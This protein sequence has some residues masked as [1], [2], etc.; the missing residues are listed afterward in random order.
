MKSFRKIQAHWA[1]RFLS[2][3][4]L[5]SLFF[6]SSCGSRDVLEV[7]QF[8]LRS[9]AETNPKD[10]LIRAE[11]QKRLYGAVTREERE[12]R[13]G[14]YYSVRWRNAENEKVRIVFDYRQA[15]TGAQIKTLS[16]EITGKNEGVVEFAIAGEN[17]EVG[18]RVLSWRVRVFDAGKLLGEK[19]SYLWE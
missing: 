3:A 6:L 17:Y 1:R 11:V 16:R 19:R 10:S 7:K 12:A 5:G 18:G 14:Q 2:I 9:L 13:V 15:S 8:T 4:L